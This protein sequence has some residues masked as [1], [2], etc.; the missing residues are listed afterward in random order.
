MLRNED[1]DQATISQAGVNREADAETSE[2]EN[3][4]TA[5]PTTA[6]QPASGGES[7]G[8]ED[9]EE[10]DQPGELTES[11]RD[12][13]RRL[14]ARDREVRTHEQAHLS[15]AGDLAIGG[16]T[17]DYQRGPDGKRYA[18]GGE[19]QIDTSSVPNDPEATLQ[20]AQRIKRAALAPAEPSSQDRRVASQ[21]D[22]MANQARRDIAEEQLNPEEGEEATTPQ[23]QAPT[24]DPATTGP[25][26]TGPTE[27]RATGPNTGENNANQAAT[28]AVG[29]GLGL[30]GARGLDGANRTDNNPSNGIS[31][32]NSLGRA[33]GN[34][35][36]PSAI[37]QQISNGGPG[38][39]GGGNFG[40]PFTYGANG[41]A[42]SER[43][44]LL[45][46]VG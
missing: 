16:P 19:V 29:S 26:A 24:A 46:L 41:Q 11:E 38:N 10:N 30:N 31:A 15:A 12:L 22:R 20:R 3:A 6:Q 21:A 27:Q 1:G 44:S 37:A 42:Q 25:T 33:G 2:T 36:P 28:A 9:E 13:V 34:N 14:Q 8:E 35:A 43:G 4:F 5:E 7:R 17:Y 23:A 39:F 45:S 32:A 18:V 40:A